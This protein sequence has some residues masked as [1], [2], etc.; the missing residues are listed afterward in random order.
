MEKRLEIEALIENLDTVIAFIDE[1]LEAIECPMKVQIQFDVAVEEIF[2][3]IAHYAYSKKD[4]SG[5]AIPDTGTGMA[6]IEISHEEGIVTVTFTDQGMPF[7]PLAKEDPDVTLSAEE[8]EIG[9]LGIYMVKNSM[10][11]VKYRYENDSNILS[12]SKSI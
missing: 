1:Y 7:D 3:N 10:D 8:R 11:C 4:E 12:I 2:V 5:K 9:G 6:A